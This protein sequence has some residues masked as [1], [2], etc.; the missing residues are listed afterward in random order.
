MF[1]KLEGQDIKCDLLYL[2]ALLTIQVAS[3]LLNK[4]ESYGVTRMLQ[5]FGWI[6]WNDCTLTELLIGLL[7]WGWFRVMNVYRWVLR[8]G[9]PRKKKKKRQCKRN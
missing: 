5:Q 1:V 6:H 2:M 7:F 3:M 4:D 9:L 8:L